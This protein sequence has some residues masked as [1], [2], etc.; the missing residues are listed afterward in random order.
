MGQYQIIKQLLIDLKKWSQRLNQG[1]TAPSL[2]ATAPTIRKVPFLFLMQ[3]MHPPQVA[4]VSRV[5]PYMHLGSA[6]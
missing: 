5:S 4:L 2:G 3:Y 6:T 1:D